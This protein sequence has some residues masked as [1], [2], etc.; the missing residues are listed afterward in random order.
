MLNIIAAL[1][2]GSTIANISSSTGWLVSGP[3]IGKSFSH[4]LRPTE[5]STLTYTVFIPKLFPKK[6]NPTTSSTILM[7]NVNHAGE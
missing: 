5:V 3:L 4:T 2:A 7:T 1:T 6:I